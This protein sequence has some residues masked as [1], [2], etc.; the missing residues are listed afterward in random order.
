[1][2]L[3]VPTGKAVTT[4][5]ARTLGVEIATRKQ[6]TPQKSTESA[7]LVGRKDTEIFNVLRRPELPKAEKLLCSLVPKPCNRLK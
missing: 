4:V 7:G 6:I 1:M 2:V 5:T 3:E